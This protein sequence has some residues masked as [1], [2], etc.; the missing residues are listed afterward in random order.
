MTTE[1][2]IAVS[3]ETC[4]PLETVPILENTAQNTA[5]PVYDNTYAAPQ[6]MQLPP[7]APPIT[8]ISTDKLFALLYVA[9]GYAFVAAFTHYDTAKNFFWFTLFYC[10]VVLGYTLAHGKR[11]SV[12]SWFWLGAML[13]ISAPYGWY[14]VLYFLQFLALLCVAAY[15]TLCVTGALMDES[16][17]KTSNWLVFDVL[18]A[19]LIVPY[20]NF[21][22][23]AKVL[24]RSVRQTKAGRTLL[25]ILLGAAIALP[26][27]CWV[28]PLLS[29]ADAG[30]AALLQ[31]FSWKI[32]LHF[33]E[34]AIRFILSVPV[35]AFLFGLVYGGLYQRRTQCISKTQIQK[36]QDTMHFLPNVAVY[37]ALAILCGVYV[38]FIGLQGKYLFSAFWNTLPEG[39]TFAE[40]A[41]S[42]F[43]ELCRIAGIN[44]SVLALANTFAG[45]PRTSST[46]LRGLNCALSVLSL[47]LLGTAASKMALY[48]A[49][50]GLTTKRVLTSVFLLWLALVF[51]ALLVWQTRKIPLVRVCTLAGVILFC[52]LCVVPVT[53]CIQQYNMARVE[54][55]TL[56]MEP[57]LRSPEDNW[58]DWIDETR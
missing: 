20:G 12:E 47:L 36:V 55:G 33:S 50:Y 13:C 51:V 35:T 7:P 54:N 26:L 53:S 3:S 39:F 11:P 41:R 38:V 6:P 16:G 18:N 45:K 57:V 49:A 9:V 31:N 30:F 1:E 15:W 19:Q 24:L 37:T 56:E 46:L 14:S 42:G 29:S 58:V 32:S 17:G 34:F 2:K 22:A 25:S 52:A 23:H 4:S 28:L 8:V 5:L 43:F 10:A 21:M 40:Y 44:L 27:L 48:I